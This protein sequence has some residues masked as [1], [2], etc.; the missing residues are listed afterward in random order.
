MSPKPR[1][2]NVCVPIHGSGKYGPTVNHNGNC[3]D[4]ETLDKYVLNSRNSAVIYSYN[5][6]LRVHVLVLDSKFRLNST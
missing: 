3:A 5:K 1:L 2:A 4:N 6:N